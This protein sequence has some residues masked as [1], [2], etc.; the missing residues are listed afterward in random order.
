MSGNFGGDSVVDETTFE[1]ESDP[2]AGGMEGG[3]GTMTGGGCS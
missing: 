2:I 1:G 3:G